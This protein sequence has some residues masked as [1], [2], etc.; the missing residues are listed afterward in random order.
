MDQ[1]NLFHYWETNGPSGVPSFRE[2]KPDLL[3]V[4]FTNCQRCAGQVIGKLIPDLICQLIDSLYEINELI[5][6][7]YKTV[8]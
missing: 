4:R 8:T 6:E 1:E 5:A 2:S 7:Q 3:Q